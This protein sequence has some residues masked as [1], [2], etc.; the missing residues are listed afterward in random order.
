M[1]EDDAHFFREIFQSIRHRLRTLS[2]ADGNEQAID[3]ALKEPRR[4]IADERFREHTHY[5][6]HVGPS[7]EHLDAVQQHRL[8]GDP[9]ELL[10]LTAAD[11]T[12]GA[13]SDDHH[14]NVGD[15]T[16]LGVWIVAELGWRRIARQMTRRALVAMM[17][18]VRA[19]VAH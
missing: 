12:A 15:D 14:A 6:R 8:A 17:I 4:R 7:V 2:A 16:A 3:V 13:G 5:H 18:F 19:S 11:T 9:A 10:E 1:H